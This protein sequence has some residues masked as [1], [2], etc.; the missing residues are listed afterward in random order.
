VNWPTITLEAPEFRTIALIVTVASSITAV[1]AGFVKEHLAV[2][3]VVPAVPTTI[4]K[5]LSAVPAPVLV[6]LKVQRKLEPACARLT[7][8]KRSDPVM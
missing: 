8:I 3:A 6:M 1:P 4:A 2:S 7:G 5:V